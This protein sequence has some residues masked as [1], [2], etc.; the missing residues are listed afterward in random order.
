M[1]RKW[2]PVDISFRNDNPYRAPPESGRQKRLQLSQFG[3][4][5]S[6]Q[7][8]AEIQSVVPGL[9]IQGGCYQ[10]S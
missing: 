2:E 7:R 8:P 3:L 4:R 10:L 1:P 6:S 5:S 9:R